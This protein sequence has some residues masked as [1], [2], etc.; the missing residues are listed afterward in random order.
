MVCCK[1]VEGFNSTKSANITANL[2]VPKLPSSVEGDNYYLQLLRRK[3]VWLAFM[4]TQNIVQVL[5]IFLHV[6]KKNKKYL[7]LTQA[8]LSLPGKL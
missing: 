4:I 6:F 8:P 1:C 3:I 2:L 7:H 5:H